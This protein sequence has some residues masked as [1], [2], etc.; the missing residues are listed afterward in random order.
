MIVQYV[1][2]NGR[3]PMWFAAC[4]LRQ[5]RCS[6][7]CRSRSGPS[8]TTPL[9]FGL[10]NP[11]TYIAYGTISLV[12]TPEPQWKKNFPL[13]LKH[14]SQGG[15]LSAVR[16]LW[17]L[18]SQ[19]IERPV[20]TPFCAAL[21][22]IF[23]TPFIYH[24]ANQRATSDLFPVSH[25]CCTRRASCLPQIYFF[26]IVLPQFQIVEAYFCRSW[27]NSTALPNPRFETSLCT[28]T[29]FKGR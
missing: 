28:A 15:S 6:A 3:K 1:T 8:Q 25:R 19:P 22:L 23:Q 24:P 7:A 27:R 10:D 14:R 29:L 17:I 11:H 20:M 12:W 16:L 21:L 9:P 5:T 18:Q 2:N 26:L 13:G 4:F